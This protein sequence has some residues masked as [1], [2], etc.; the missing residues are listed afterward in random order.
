M[1]NELLF[2]HFFALRFSGFRIR[3]EMRGPISYENLLLSYSCHFHKFPCA[4][5]ARSGDLP[6]WLLRTEGSP[7]MLDFQCQH[8]KVSGKLGQIGHPLWP[9]PLG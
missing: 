1:R 8:W 7:G 2:G 3:R 5:S 4:R 6:S 9:L